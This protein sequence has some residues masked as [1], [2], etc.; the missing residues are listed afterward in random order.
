MGTAERVDTL[1]GWQL[2]WRP[3]Q[4]ILFATTAALAIDWA[5]VQLVVHAS[6]PTSALKYAHETGR[7]RH[8]GQPTR[9]V[10]LVPH[11]WQ[12][13][14]L[15]LQATVWQRNDWQTLAAL[16]CATLTPACRWQRLTAYLDGNSGVTP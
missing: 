6:P 9:C 15:L 14:P 4:R 2:G 1:A 13:P 5:H 10:T 12:P 8:N 16:F 7:A 11:G 3:A